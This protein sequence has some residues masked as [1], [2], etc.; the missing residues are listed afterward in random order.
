MKA[1]QGKLSENIINLLGYL[2]KDYRPF[3]LRMI[4]SKDECD[5]IDVPCR[6]SYMEVPHFLR[7]GHMETHPWCRLQVHG[8]DNLSGHV[9]LWEVSNP[10][11]WTLVFMR[12][13]YWFQKVTG[14]LVY[15]EENGV[16]LLKSWNIDPSCWCKRWYTRG[17]LCLFLVLFSCILIG[18]MC[19]LVGERL[20]S[21]EAHTPKSNV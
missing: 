9:W 3:V 2:V 4:G 15:I 13:W 14:S 10:G 17:L 12:H 19:A 11:L 6:S 7:P 21:R 1:G 8:L 16:P 5:T 18:F 20:V